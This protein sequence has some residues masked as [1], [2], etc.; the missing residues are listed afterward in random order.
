MRGSPFDCL[1][2]AKGNPIQEGSK[3]SAREVI[4]NILGALSDKH[5]LEA[6]SRELEVASHVVEK[7]RVENV[8]LLGES[9]GYQATN[10]VLSGRARE[11]LER[12]SQQDKGKKIQE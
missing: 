6:A 9:A 5:K 1:K 8:R 7:Y 2:T 3:S 11:G 12:P 10:K 4:K